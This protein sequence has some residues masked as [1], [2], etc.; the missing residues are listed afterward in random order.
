MIKTAVDVD[1]NN[2]DE[3]ATKS[4]QWA[5]NYLEAH[6]LLS[7]VRLIKKT[8]RMEA[9]PKVLKAVNKTSHLEVLECNSRGH[10]VFKWKNAAEKTMFLLKWS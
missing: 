4:Y 10:V 7:L 2:E 9:F 8:K 3:I 1:H 6:D 5:H